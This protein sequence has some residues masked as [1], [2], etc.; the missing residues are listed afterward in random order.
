MKAQSLPELFLI[1]RRDLGL[2]LAARS[3]HGDFAAYHCCFK[4]TEADLYC[5]CGQEKTPEHAFFCQYSRRND[6]MH[7][8]QTRQNT[9]EY[10]RWTLST[11][12]GAQAFHEWIIKNWLFN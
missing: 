11:K 1:L 5:S 4:H 10:E 9:M 7:S 12:E 3:G 6:I 2:L 8:N